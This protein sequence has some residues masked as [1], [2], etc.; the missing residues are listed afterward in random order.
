MRMIIITLPLWAAI[1]GCLPPQSQGGPRG[2]GGGWACPNVSDACR[3]ADELIRHIGERISEMKLGAR[4]VEDAHD[5][6]SDWFR[7][8]DKEANRCYF[9][10]SV[11]AKQQLAEIESLVKARE[12]AISYQLDARMDAQKTAWEERQRREREEVA[13]EIEAAQKGQPPKRTYLLEQGPLCVNHPTEPYCTFWWGEKKELQCDVTGLEPRVECRCTP[14]DDL[15]C[16]HD[17]LVFEPGLRRMVQKLG[18]PG[19]YQAVQRTVL[20]F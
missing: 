15:Y 11:H 18:G 9:C 3:R 6:L 7:E 10:D 8:A 14:G 12:E 20:G 19:F 4:A 13:A 2:T 1:S 17:I 16:R 5:E